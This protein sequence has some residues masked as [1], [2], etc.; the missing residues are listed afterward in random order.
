MFYSD[1][2]KQI[3]NE[4]YENNI[5]SFEET[6]F[7]DRKARRRP[8]LVNREIPL[9]LV[10]ETHLKLSVFGRFMHQFNPDQY[11]SCMVNEN[12]FLLETND[13]GEFTKQDLKYW[14]FYHSFSENLFALLK[15]SIEEKRHIDL[16]YFQE[17]L[18]ILRLNNGSV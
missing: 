4:R 18:Q 16:Q 1:E 7:R 13:I 11:R 10:L 14:D 5:W 17:N 9:S 2:E 3:L 12:K 8:K 6:C 15:K